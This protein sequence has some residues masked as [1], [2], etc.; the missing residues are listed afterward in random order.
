MTSTTET[1]ALTAEQRAQITQ[2][3][4]YEPKTILRDS[5]FGQPWQIGRKRNYEGLSVIPTG[6][7][8][9]MT[10]VGCKDRYELV[11]DGG[12]ENDAMLL[13]LLDDTTYEV[14]WS[15]TPKPETLYQHS[16]DRADTRVC[17]RCGAFV[18]DGHCVIA[19]PTFKDGDQVTW[20]SP[21]SAKW[22][23]GRIEK[24]I[25]WSSRTDAAIDVDREPGRKTKITGH[26]SVSLLQYADTATEEPTPPS[27]RAELEA[28]R[29]ELAL[30]KRC[31]SAM[32]SHVR[33]LERHPCI[34]PPHDAGTVHRNR[35]GTEWYE[36][37][38]GTSVVRRI[39]ARIREDNWQSQSPAWALERLRELLQLS[40]TLPDGTPQEVT[41]RLADLR[42]TLPD[43]LDTDTE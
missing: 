17:H 6:E 8:A 35:Y 30:V 38:E 16:P 29:A 7:V 18:E 27:I 25:E 40:D 42:V 24:F 21:W 12:A 22:E 37:P 10:T 32:A 1:P 13:D 5:K 23:T 41:V 11:L 39:D 15:P 14:I 31:G 4:A 19:P 28:A 2:L 36:A 26:V 33:G 20:Y 3:A 34:L 43:G 9:V